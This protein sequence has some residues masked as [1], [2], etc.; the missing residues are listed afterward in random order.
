MY[1]KQF[2]FKPN[3]TTWM[4]IPYGELDKEIN[5]ELFRKYFIFD[6]RKLSDD[7]LDRIFNNFDEFNYQL[8]ED[9]FFKTI[10]E[11]YFDYRKNMM[12]LFVYSEDRKYNID[13]YS[14]MSNMKFA[15]KKF[16]TE[17]ELQDIISKS[18][19]VTN[20][21]NI[22]TS[23]NGNE[24]KHGFNLISGLNGSGKTVLL[25][26]ISNHFNTPIF[27]MD[28]Y[29]LDL[30]KSI[31]DFS[32][33]KKYL[34]R[35]NELNRYDES[36]NI[37]NYFYRLSQILAF[38]KDKNNVVLLDNLCWRLLD[39]RNKI[40]ILDTL[41]DYICDNSTSIVV[42]SC[43]SDVKRLVKNRIYKSNIIE[44]NQKR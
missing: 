22:Y 34:K 15:L 1:Q 39:D 21:T 11:E 17:S 33:V 13:R 36:S 7:E 42:T 25:N 23:I 4:D 29:Y 24:I 37:R 19:S 10:N 43:Q 27:N 5:N 8:L 30:I 6:I 18:S 31:E 41:F 9:I 2:V 26:E 35:L 40:N 44:V 38:C 32:Q 28:D 20:P 12:V 3:A 14:A 16:V